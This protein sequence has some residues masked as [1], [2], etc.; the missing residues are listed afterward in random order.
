MATARKRAKAETKRERV[1]ELSGLISATRPQFEQTRVQLEAWEVELDELL[2]GSDSAEPREEQ[3]RV[4]GSPKA[5]AS[6]KTAPDAGKESG[7]GELTATLRATLKSMPAEFTGREWI[8]AAGIPEDRTGSAFAAISRLLL[9]SKEIVKSTTHGKYR[10]AAS[11][12]G[13]SPSVIARVVAQ[14]RESQAQA[15]IPERILALLASEPETTFDAPAIGKRFGV[16]DRMGLNSI[17]GALSRLASAKR[18]EKV[19]RGDYKHAA[20]RKIA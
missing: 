7:R 11:Q 8:E 5:K 13:T 17:R 4:K 6:R 9:K 18:I 20:G 2:F 10:R 16:S 12:R 3:R 14:V 19:G 15:P 1:I